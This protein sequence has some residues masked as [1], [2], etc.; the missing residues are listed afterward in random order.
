MQFIVR[1]VQ[2]DGSE[3]W[4]LHTQGN[5]TERSRPGKYALE[6]TKEREEAIGSIP[7]RRVETRGLT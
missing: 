3:T 6:G 4:Q 7:P 5:I 1:D 2:T